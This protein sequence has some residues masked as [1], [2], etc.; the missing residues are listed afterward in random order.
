MKR[1][2]SW[3]LSRRLRAM[4]AVA[5]LVGFAWGIELVGATSPMFQDSIP[6]NHPEQNPGG[7]AATF[8][9]QGAVNLTGEYF[10]AQGTNG[11]SCASCHTPEEAWSINPGTLRTPVRRNGWH[12]PGLQPARR[13]QP[14]YG[15][16]HAG[17]PPRRLQHAPESRRIPQGRRSPAKLRVGADRRR[18]PARFR[19]PQPARALAALHADDQL[20]PRERDGQ[21]GRRQQHRHRPARRACQPGHPQRDR[22]SAGSAGAS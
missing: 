7:F 22:R 4:I 5:A 1:C 16:L 10:Q 6:N 19:Q 14:E 3:N 17:G 15:R 8:S 12:S 20:R 11:R 9:T 13:Q 21:L 18:R 2:S